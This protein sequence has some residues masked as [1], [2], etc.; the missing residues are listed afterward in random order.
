MR[1]LV[2]GSRDWTDRGAVYRALHHHVV[3]QHW[4]KGYDSKGIFVN[5]VKPDD[6]VLVH[7]ACPTGAD[8]IADDWCIGWHFVAERHPAD[9]QQHGKRAGFLRNKHMVDLG[10]DLCLAF[11]NPCTKTGCGHRDA[12]G[13][14]E[15]HDSHGAA[16]TAALCEGRGIPVIRVRP[17]DRSNDDDVVHG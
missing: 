14:Y 5:W 4:E 12:R 2:T 9:W 7:G 15:Q 3:D 8:A 13:H 6:F 16:M 1:V 11:L 17:T 10:V